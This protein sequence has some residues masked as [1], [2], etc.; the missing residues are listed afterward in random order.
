MGQDFSSIIKLFSELGLSRRVQR[1]G[2]YLAG[3]KNPE[4]MAEHAF[5][6]AL[7]G[8]T[9]AHLERANP[10]KTASMLLWQT[11]SQLRVGDQHKISSRYYEVG[12]A[13][14]R[15]IIDQIQNLPK[16]LANRVQTL[17]NHYWDRDTKEGVVAKDADWLETAI[18]AKE[19][20][21]RGYQGMQNWI[22]NVRKALETD[23][24]KKLLKEIESQKDFTNSWWQGLK[25]MTYRKL[26]S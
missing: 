26:D 9:L 25:K 19:Y 8:Y 20:L 18:T 22:D 7:I 15:A 21:E 10:E 2:S 5:R 6:A 16:P 23:S 3:V 4:N 12:S 14:K 13:Q 17:A 11:A 1:T 24:A